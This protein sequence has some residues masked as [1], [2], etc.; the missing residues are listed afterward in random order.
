MG[1]AGDLRT[2]L[3]GHGWGTDGV[4]YRHCPSGKG[5]NLWTACLHRV[6]KGEI[7]GDKIRV[8]SQCSSE[9]NHNSIN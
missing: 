1:D 6:R 8:G 4:Y 7:I 2:G 3:R 9:N 5:S